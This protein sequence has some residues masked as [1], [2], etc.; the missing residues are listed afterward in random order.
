[1]KEVSQAINF[2]LH[3]HFVVLFCVGLCHI[4]ELD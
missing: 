1:M 3:Y 2:H 4:I